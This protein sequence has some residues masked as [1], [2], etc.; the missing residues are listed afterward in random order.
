MTEAAGVPTTQ[1]MAP[2]GGVRVDAGPG[3]NRPLTEIASGD[4]ATGGVR[5]PSG[6]IL[7][8][9]GYFNNMGVGPEADFIDRGINMLRPL[10]DNLF[11][12]YT[13]FANGALT[14]G[15]RFRLEF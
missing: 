4:I 6:T 11:H 12:D 2:P 9:V 1:Q 15:G 3:I 5:S 7:D 14:E 13:G 10:V 8:A